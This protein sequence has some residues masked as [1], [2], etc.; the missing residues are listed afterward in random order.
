MADKNLS[1]LIR[2]AVI[3]NTALI[4]PGPAYV[5]YALAA[6]TATTTPGS[7][8]F[9][10]PN[11]GVTK[12]YAFINGVIIG[13]YMGALPGINLS[14]NKLP[15]SEVGSI[16]GLAAQGTADVTGIAAA[17]KLIDVSGG[18]N[19]DPAS[20]FSTTLLWEGHGGDLFIKCN[21]NGYPATFDLSGISSMV[22]YGV[23]LRGT[24]MSSAQVNALLAFVR[25]QNYPG[26]IGGASTIQID[27]PGMGAPTGQ[28][29][30]DK[31]WIIAGGW[32]VNSN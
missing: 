4:Q 31:T 22:P 6:L 25:A 21:I 17:D 19:A 14:G 12:A 16:I 26:N 11:M 29:L 24:N 5:A 15:Q 27:G 32:F 8:N 18:S 20:G 30:T 28:G 9:I 13:Q 10:L 7:I 3:P 2:N 23:N 1:D